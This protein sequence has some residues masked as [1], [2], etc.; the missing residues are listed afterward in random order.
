M[1][2]KKIIL[3]IDPGTRITG[4]GVIDWNP[5]NPARPHVVT[6]TVAAALSTFVAIELLTSYNR[7]WCTR[8]S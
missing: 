7:I 2:N 5:A 4:Y 8:M 1:T 3:G 6:T